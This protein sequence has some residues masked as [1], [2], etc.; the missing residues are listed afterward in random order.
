VAESPVPEENISFS[1]VS[2]GPFNT[3]MAHLGLT[4]SDRLPAW[5]T[6]LFL[7]L[8]VWAP[9]AILAI[10]QSLLQANYSGWDFFQDGTVYTR[11]LVAI[12]AMVATERFA[13]GRISMLV[14]QFLHSGLLEPGASGRFMAIVARADRQS[15]RPSV[16]IILVFIALVW[17]WLSFYFVATTSVGGWED[18]TTG[19][20]THMSW[21]G[22]IAEIFSNPVFLFLVLRWFWRFLTWTMLLARIARLPLRL[23]ATHPDQAGGL[24]FLTLFPGIFMGLVFA[25]SCVISSSLLKSIALVSPSQL[26]IW[27]AIGIWVLLMVL[28]FLGPLSVFAGPMYRAREKAMLEYG[29]LAQVH[30]QAFHNTWISSDQSSKE[31]LGSPDPSS[32][33]DLNACVQAAHSMRVVPL[34]LGAILQI[35]LAATVPFLAVV[36]SQIPVLQLLQWLLGALL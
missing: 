9:P 33:A 15:S 14:N 21:A 19:G 25:L 13:D 16:E 20:E 3:L 10:A 23:T 26:F 7:A 22:T 31:L 1:L 6:A 12:V 18:W 11:Y 28:I 30:H 29:K 27:L 24:G 34:N 2:G 32:V 8:L 36:I 5:R 4:G 17:S 35:L